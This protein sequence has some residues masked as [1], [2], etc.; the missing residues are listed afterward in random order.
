VVESSNSHL[1]ALTSAF[2][3][4]AYRMEKYGHSFLVVEMGNRLADL[5][6]GNKRLCDCCLSASIHI[7]L[8]NR[9]HHKAGRHSE[10]YIYILLPWPKPTQARYSVILIARPGY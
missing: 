6:C 4:V 10:M 7:P 8:H 1:G 9:D 5:F 2:L 3:S